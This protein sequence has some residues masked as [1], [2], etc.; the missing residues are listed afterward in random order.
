MKGNVQMSEIS[1]K[2]ACFHEFF[3]SDRIAFSREKQSKNTAILF[4]CPIVFGQPFYL[5]GSVTLLIL[6][7]VQRHGS[8][9]LLPV[10][11]GATSRSKKHKPLA[12]LQHAA[13]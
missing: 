8:E 1:R 10:V 4:F 2:S 3:I 12:L 11:F 7:P 6:F 13:P 9:K 5:T